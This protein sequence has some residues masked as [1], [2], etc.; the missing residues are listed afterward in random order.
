ML[1]QYRLGGKLVYC[2]VVEWVA[3]LPF[4]LSAVHGALPGCQETVR[5][6]RVALVITVLGGDRGNR[7]QSKHLTL[8]T[9][10]RLTGHPR[11]ST[12]WAPGSRGAHVQSPVP[13]DPITGL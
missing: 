4:M 13:V 10:N 1:G 8:A 2:T 9:L 5:A 11:V 7:L 12:C 6:V 3:V